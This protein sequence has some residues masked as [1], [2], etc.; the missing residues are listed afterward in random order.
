MAKG[1]RAAMDMV[2]L[3]RQIERDAVID[4]LRDKI[5]AAQKYVRHGRINAEQCRFLT[6]CLDAAADEIGQGLHR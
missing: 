3:E 1:K 2:A 5:A 4:H 6:D